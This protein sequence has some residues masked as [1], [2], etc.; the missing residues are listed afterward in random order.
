MQHPLLVD[1][2]RRWCLFTIIGNVRDPAVAGLTAGAE[3]TLHPL[4]HAL[5]LRLPRPHCGPLDNNQ[6]A[7]GIHPDL[8]QWGEGE[9]DWWHIRTGQLAPGF[10][11]DNF[12]PL[13]AH[14]RAVSPA[15]GYFTNCNNA[16][17]PGFWA[18]DSKG[19]YGLLYRS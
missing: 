6:C 16:P 13:E 14:P 8:P 4:K 7:D 10:N 18:N 12:L 3:D 17:A 5:Q 2:H 11:F 1:I 19:S 15:S 9:F